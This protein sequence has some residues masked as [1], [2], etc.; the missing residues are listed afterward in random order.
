MGVWVGGPI[1]EKITKL[2]TVYEKT[3]TRPEQVMRLG[4]IKVIIF[5]DAGYLI[6]C[7]SLMFPMIFFSITST[8]R[9]RN[10][11]AVLT[12]IIIR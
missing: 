8:I 7:I 9:K 5:I 11:R 12:K 3:T 1:I 4:F 10:F 6:I 2:T